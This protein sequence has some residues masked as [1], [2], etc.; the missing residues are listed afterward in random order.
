MAYDPVE[1]SA[2]QMARFYT[3][4]G[5]TLSMDTPPF[6]P[7]PKAS[8]PMK[9]VGLFSGQ[10]LYYA[11]HGHFT[12]A[13]F[14]YW[15]G[16]ENAWLCDSPKELPGVASRYGASFD[17]WPAP[18]GGLLAVNFYNE[19]KT[20]N[21]PLPAQP[22]GVEDQPTL[23][24]AEAWA[25]E[26]NG[27]MGGAV[28][29]LRVAHHVFEGAP[30][31][32]QSA[33]QDEPTTRFRPQY[34]ALAM[35]EKTLHD[36]IK[37][38]AEDLLALYALIAQ[39]RADARPELPLPGMEPRRSLASQQTGIPDDSF[40]RNIALATTHLEDSVMRAIRALTM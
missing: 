17:L 9:R 15:N 21:P 36:M 2:R 40:G 24:G 25:R 39:T 27:L 38:R 28:G 26:P 4:R 8:A 3:E 35:N 14:Y 11:P 31:S 5:I 18:E 13:G 6:P 12:V 20:K 19:A 10:A 23:P 30:D 37:A 7:H 32:R 29:T 34:R 16:K 22:P 33:N 1:W